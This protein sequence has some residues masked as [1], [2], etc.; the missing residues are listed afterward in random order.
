MVE[1][2]FRWWGERHCVGHRHEARPIDLE[3]AMEP[4]GITFHRLD[5]QRSTRPDRLDALQAPL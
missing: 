3:D 1:A 2:S 4:G 5:A